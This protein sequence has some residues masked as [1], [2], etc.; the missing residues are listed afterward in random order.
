MARY[1]QVNRFWYPLSAIGILVLAACFKD[2]IF[3]DTL[4]TREIEGLYIPAQIIFSTA[5]LLYGVT[6]VFSNVRTNRY[7]KTAGIL[8]AT[9][10]AILVFCMLQISGSADFPLK[11]KLQKVSQVTL[12]IASLIPINFM[13]HFRRERK[14]AI[15]EAGNIS[16]ARSL[17]IFTA[18]TG[19]IALGFS[20]HLGYRLAI[21]S[22]VAIVAH[23]FTTQDKRK[24]DEFEARYYLSNAGDT[25]RYRVMRPLEYDPAKKYPMIVCLHHGGAHGTDN[26]NQIGGSDALLFSENFYR[27]KY[28][29]FLFV[30]QSP[31]GTG[32][33]DPVM[34]LMVMETMRLLEKEFSIDRNRLYVTGT[35]GGGYGSWHF[36]GKHPEIFAAAIPRCGAGETT[37]AKNM[38]DVAV[39]AFHGD[40]DDMVPVSGSRN[41][42]AA[43]RK[44]GGNPKYT[45]YANVGHDLGKVYENTPDLLDWLFAQKRD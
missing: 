41:M 14:L 26:I 12:W 37:D 29:A 22:S 19:L 44:A 25:L 5:N 10:G 16:L 40:Q 24:A 21:Q 33:W 28:P 27:E 34:D 18:L 2:Y 36:I 11:L 1:F 15:P 20:L 9:I 4:S 17:K 13:L 3:Y 45:E 35:S 7:L 31:E 8:T 39:W 42:I 43:I 30:P 32:W 38:V 6:L 23:G